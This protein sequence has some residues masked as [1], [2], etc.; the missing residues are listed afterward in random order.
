MF[1]STGGCQQLIKFDYEFYK[2]LGDL[3][4]FQLMKI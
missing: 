3:K 4:G 1:Y 2:V